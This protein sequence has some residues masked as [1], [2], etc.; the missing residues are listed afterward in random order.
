MLSVTIKGAGFTAS[1]KLLLDV[2]VPSLTIRAILAEPSWFDVGVK[3]TVRLPPVPPRTIW[4]VAIRLVF[5]EN[6]TTTR[7]DAAV[8]AS[9]IVNGI[10]AVAVFRMVD[11]FAMALMIGAVFVD[12]GATV[13]EGRRIRPDPTRP[14]P[15][16]GGT[17]R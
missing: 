2:N 4:L 7:F 8:S 14:R 3:V 9:E 10:A 1:T 12:T 16:T 17:R 6:A 13:G 15:G 11:W 5:D